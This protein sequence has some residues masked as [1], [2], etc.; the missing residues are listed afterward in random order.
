MP[1]HSVKINRAFTQSQIGK[2]PRA[3]A[4][5]LSLIPG[6]LL[7][8]ISSSS[9]ALLLD[10]LDQSHRNGRTVEAQSILAEG[11]IYDPQQN[12]LREIAT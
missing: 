7:P 1:D 9:L 3:R 6:S 12:K 11:A 5:A 4:E 8:W 10:A 2:F